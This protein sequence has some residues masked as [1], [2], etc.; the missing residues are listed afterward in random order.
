MVY[1]TILTPIYNGIEY[2]DE[3]VQSVINQTFSDWVMLVGINGHG[4]DGGDVAKIAQEIAKKD[5]RIQ[6]IIQPSTIKGKVESLNNLMTFVVSDWVCLLDCDDKW[7]PQKLEAQINALQ[8]EAKDA[9]VIG[10]RCQYFGELQS[11]PN[12]PTGYIHPEILEQFNPIIN[13]SAMI[14]REYCKWEYNDINFGMEDYYLW[15]ELC[16]TGKKLYNI[17][18]FFTYHRIH[19]QSS[20]NS[21]GYSNTGI[22]V[23]YAML[24]KIVDN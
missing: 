6:V 13:S 20:F 24:R 22:R 11:F 21:K 7:H 19:K 14:K 17:S 16:L 8:N 3:C 15:T 18:S 12:I 1:T 23:R 2:F 4:D 9:D 10:T 5:K